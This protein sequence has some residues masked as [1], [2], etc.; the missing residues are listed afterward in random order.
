MQFSLRLKV[1]QVGASPVSSRCP[2]PPASCRGQ[3]PCVRDNHPP[4]KTAEEPELSFTQTRSLTPA[5]GV[6]R[7]CFPKSGEF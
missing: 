1:R 5:R 2:D 4:E 7:V 3:E 6:I